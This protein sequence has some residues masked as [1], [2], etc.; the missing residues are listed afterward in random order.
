MART[1]QKQKRL[2]RGG[3][4]P[5]ELHIKDH[6]DLDNYDDVVT[7]LESDTLECEVR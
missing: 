5:E 6:N 7:H 4:N 3:K 1:K 2:R